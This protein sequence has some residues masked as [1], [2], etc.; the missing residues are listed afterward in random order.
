MLS[1][2]HKGIA[3]TCT[4]LCLII[5][6]WFVASHNSRVSP[7]ITASE[8][9]EVP[10][11]SLCV[12]SVIGSSINDLKLPLLAKQLHGR[13][14]RL[15][16]TMYPTFDATELSE[17]TFIPETKLRPTLWVFSDYPLHALIRVGIASGKTE[18]YQERPFTI[19]GVFQIDILTDDGKVEA[20]Y[21]IRNAEI[22]RK[23]IFLRFAPAVAFGC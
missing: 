22:V 18:D 23:N 14:V 20:V 8:V 6:A 1:K 11:D 16:G 19:E 17:F 7:L 3:V 13:R 5:T 9:V 21:R 12:A 2:T 10:V 4:F 15:H